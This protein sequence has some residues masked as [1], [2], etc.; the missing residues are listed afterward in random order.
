[1]QNDEEYIIIWD[2]MEM[3]D[4]KYNFYNPY[5]P[6]GGILIKSFYLWLVI[7]LPCIL[8]DEKIWPHPE[9]KIKVGKFHDIIN[10]GY[11]PDLL[12]KSGDSRLTIPELRT[13]FEYGVSRTYL[14][15]DEILIMILNMMANDHELKNKFREMRLKNNR[16][17]KKNLRGLYEKFL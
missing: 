2:N 12:K 7:N 1:M 17:I 11:L 8:N 5:V 9:I 16:Y 13:I 15:L 10:I 4:P 3:T 6:V 14:K